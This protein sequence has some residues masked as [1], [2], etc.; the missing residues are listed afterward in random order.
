MEAMRRFAGDGV[1]PPEVGRLEESV[2]GRLSPAVVIMFAYAVWVFE[3]TSGQ[4]EGDGVLEETVCGLLTDVGEAGRFRGSP[5][6]GVLV[7]RALMGDIGAMAELVAGGLG[8]VDD[9]MGL[10]HAAWLRD[11]L[12]DGELDDLLA[13]GEAAFNESLAAGEL[14]VPQV[15]DGEVGPWDAE[16]EVP[17]W[18]GGRI[19]LGALKLPVLPGMR[20]HPEAAEDGEVFGV[21][22][23]LGPLFLQLQAFTASGPVWDRAR[24]EM[25]AEIIA[26][27]GQ[28]REGDGP[29]GPDIRGTI[30]RSRPGP[31]PVRY[32]GC[33][34][35]GWLLR[36]VLTGPYADAEAVAEPLRTMFVGTVVDL[37][38]TRAEPDAPVPLKW[39]PLSGWNEAK[40]PLFDTF[41]VSGEVFVP[42]V[43]DGAVG[44]WDVS[45]ET[46]PDMQR[47]DMGALKLP[48]IPG[49]R[50]RPDQ[51]DGLVCGVAVRVGADTL[52]LRVFHE[53]DGAAWDRVREGI[54]H[55][56]A[57]ADVQGY[58]GMGQ[59]GPDVRVVEVLNADGLE[60][61]QQSGRFVGC[62]GPDWLLRGALTGP[63]A[64]ADLIVEQ[65]RQ[66]FIGSVVDLE[67]AE[68]LAHGCVP[69][70][71]PPRSGWNEAEVPL[72]D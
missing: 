36:G 48:V 24:G 6:H 65:L 45:D 71:W 7:T 58:E 72:I 30:L 26:Q 61:E 37:R 43:R 2:R 9:V 1:V 64:D 12:S 41:L 17:E 57:D 39:P 22:V 11:G 42:Q 27:G 50:I 60:Q 25:V 66:V 54:L 70:Q 33:E 3:T 49:M 56:L 5:A 10:L 23:K 21:T 4:P 68:P 55:Q 63:S 19:D 35:P 40:V 62:D 29:L 32:V 18:P 46:V 20:I 34:G 14:L 67:D 8:S 51:D 13:Q 53:P 69:L 38:E 47:I 59:L 28:A 15:R 16:Q 44:P 52:M 31:V